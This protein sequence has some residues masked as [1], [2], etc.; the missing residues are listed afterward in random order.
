ME[1]EP[2]VRPSPIAGQ[3]YPSDPLLLSSSVDKYLQAA[4]LPKIAGRVIAVMSPHAGHRYSGAVA[5]YAF[6]ALLGQRP[7]MVAVVSPMHYPYYQPLL[8]TVHSAYCTPLGIIPVDHDA[9]R[10]IDEYLRAELGFGLT[11]LRNDPE[12][13]LEI[14]LPFLQRALPAGFRLVPLMVREHNPRVISTLGSALAETLRGREAVMVAST[15]LSHFYPQEVA[16][17]LDAELL[18][19]VAGLDPQGVLAAEEEGRGFACGR[20]ALAAVLWAAKALG[21]DAAKV[22][23]YTTSGE[24]TGDLD[25]VVGYAAAVVYQKA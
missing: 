8:S 10:Q 16:E 2:N 3:W 1:T 24:V 5:G 25:Q 17:S 15:D 7:E 13:S 4:R 12:H 21:A 23:H 6:K 14:V 20:S 9:L 22:L 18:K 19:R 11:L